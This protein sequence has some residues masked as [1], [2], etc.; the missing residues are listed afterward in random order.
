M[1]IGNSVLLIVKKHFKTIK[2]KREKAEAS[3]YPANEAHGD[4]ESAFIF[5]FEEERAPTKDGGFTSF[6]VYRTSVA[7]KIQ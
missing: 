3:Q 7:L 1:F 2:E 5:L 6:K 4:H